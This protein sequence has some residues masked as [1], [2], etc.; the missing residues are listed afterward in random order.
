MV[1]VLPA[2]LRLLPLKVR[3]SRPRESPNLPRLLTL[4]RECVALPRVTLRAPPEA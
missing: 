4:C 1:E 3:F 2:D